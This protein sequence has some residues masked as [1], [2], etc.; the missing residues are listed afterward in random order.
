MADAAAQSTL[1]K[2]YARRITLAL[3]LAAAAAAALSCD[4][5]SPGKSRP[6]DSA[7]TNRGAFRVALLTPG[8]ISDR[9]WNGGA[10][11]GLLAIRDSLGAQISHVQ[12]KTPAEFEEN[13]R[14]YGAQGYDLVI[15]HGFEFQDAAVRVAPEFPKT[16]YITTSGNTVR[17]NVA[18]IQFAFEEASYLA[19]ML[20]AGTTKTGTI[21]A[22]GGTEL[23]PVKRSFAAYAAGARS[24]KPG[25]NVLISYIG[26]WD[27]VGAGKEQALAQITRKADVI[28]QNADA[29]GLGVFQAARESRASY[30]IGANADQNAVAPEVTLGSVVIDLRHAFLLVAQQVKSHTFVPSVVSLGVRDNVVRLV[31]NPALESRVSPATR[32]AIDSVQ[33]RLFDGSLR[34]ND[35][36]GM[37]ASQ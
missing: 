15:G 9:A 35:S 36:T 28:F 25:L 12:T 31:M 18:G 14:Q 24:L 19:G 8:P 29:A 26:N 33:R 32:A 11:D 37:P 16:L 1:M 27:D 2:Q 3:R 21:G 13:F 6:N 4:G 30:V 7:S 22:I 20:A 17:S 34:L 23:P 10:Y 5:A